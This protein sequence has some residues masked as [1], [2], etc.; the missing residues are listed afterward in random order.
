MTAFK[1]SQAKYVK[2]SFK[3]TNWPE[4]EAGLRQRGSV[5]VWISEEELRGWGPPERGQ[6]K[7]GGQQRYSNHA[8][9]TALTVGM[10]FHL[11]LRQTEGFLSSLFSL[12]DLNCRVPENTMTTLGMPETHQVG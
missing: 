8:I 12:L 10:V 9:E 1:R 2:D 3:T 6:L 7:P 4:Y 5:T 11:R